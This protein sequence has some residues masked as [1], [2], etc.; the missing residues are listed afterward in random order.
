MT[1][2]NIQCCDD[3]TTKQNPNLSPVTSVN[4]NNNNNDNSINNN[5]NKN[6]FN[7]A[8]V[9]LKTIKSKIKLNGSYS[10]TLLQHASSVSS[11]NNNGNNDGRSE[12]LDKQITNNSSNSMFS[13][14]Q[15]NII[16]NSNSIDN[17]KSLIK[18]KSITGCLNNANSTK[19]VI[20]EVPSGEKRFQCNENR[21][22]SISYE[23]EEVGENHLNV[24]DRSVT[25]C[26]KGTGKNG[27]DG[28]DD[29]SKQTAASSLK[30]NR[31][32]DTNCFSMGNDIDKVV[33]L[34]TPDLIGLKT[35][36]KTGNSVEKQT[37]ET[38]ISSSCSSTSNE[39]NNEI[40]VTKGDA[41]RPVNN[42]N[43]QDEFEKKLLNVTH[44]RNTNPF[45]NDIYET[46]D[47]EL[48]ISEPEG[49]AAVS[50]IEN[51]HVKLNSDCDEKLAKTPPITSVVNQKT[52]QSLPTGVWIEDNLEKNL[53]DYDGDSD[54]LC[55]SE[56]FGARENFLHKTFKSSGNDLT[57]KNCIPEQVGRNVNHENDR[58]CEVVG[59]SDQ[60][61]ILKSAIPT[62]PFQRQ[63][64]K[65]PGE[66]NSD[67]N[68]TGS[69]A[70]R[71]KKLFKLSKKSGNLFN[72]PSF[73]KTNV[74]TPPTLKHVNLH[75]PDKTC[76]S[77]VVDCPSEKK[78]FEKFHSKAKYQLIKLG[79]KCKILTHHQPTA[80]LPT[81]MGSVR[82][83]IIKTNTNH[84]KKYQYY[85]E[86]NK[87]YQLDD[88]IR[89]THLLNGGSGDDDGSPNGSEVDVND[90]CR[91]GNNDNRN[92]VI[93]K[94]Y[95]SEIDLTRNLTYLDAFLNEHFEREALTI[96]P[97]EQS[98]TA[99]NHTRHKQHRRMK[100]CSKNINYSTNAIRHDQQASAV[101]INDANFDGNDESVDDDCEARNFYDG[102]VTSSSFEYTSVKE[103]RARKDV[104]EIISG[105]SNTTSSSLS[106]SDYAS[107][108]SGGSKDGKNVTSDV[109]SKLISTPEESI[110]Y[111]DASFLEKKNNQKRIRSRR[112]SQPIPEHTNCYQED[113]GDQFLLFD[114][115]N[116]VELKTNMRKFHPDLYNSVPQF[117]DLNAIEFYEN[118]QY[119]Q[120]NGD[121]LINPYAIEATQ[122]SQRQL[123]S[124]YND[125]STHQDY[126]EH[127]HQ[128]QLLGHGDIDVYSSNVCSTN[129][130]NYNGT[131]ART[132]TV[133]THLKHNKTP[134]D[135][136]Q[137]L[138]SNSVNDLFDARKVIQKNHS[139]SIASYG[140]PHRVIVSKSK[141]QKG[142]LVLEYEC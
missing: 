114:E 119:H 77:S 92:S 107:V 85:N 91:A 40:N 133:S 41:G 49:M 102:N 10:L 27:E 137:S 83:T 76:S 118:P 22:N 1:D 35:N 117:E 57:S 123:S 93:Y 115:A 6:N 34:K 87:S 100:S 73:G 71:E 86:I 56:I 138:A 101:V 116:F 65:R 124:S 31:S 28:G 12:T 44:K 30:A 47:A 130:S 106:S 122:A 55:N 15:D 96:E 11:P 127:F 45:L 37:N 126:L 105:K 82:T 7:F 19:E 60:S 20:D 121:S 5:N 64:F 135:Y 68:D 39:N 111:Y 8:R 13:N 74:K 140:H 43:I 4:N 78:Y 141:K 120:G 97:A 90:A 61:F 125:R 3:S 103:K 53:L 84:R 9:S 70:R 81:R 54:E 48:T 79:Q 14:N 94:S 129:S 99:K 46:A 18:S 58:S 136:N 69:G 23:N 32:N 50:M 16:Y 132:A 67:I 88:F 98:P 80:T 95:K 110:E 59:N 26:D 21:I 142:E 51:G 38:T 29:F 109:K 25:D 72:I 128:Q 139:Q 62:C 24:C 104:Q 75:Y 66:N 112:S 131:R 89:T 33:D 42:E 63:D 134:R 108:Y 2:D 36:G 17:N 52:P 113:Y